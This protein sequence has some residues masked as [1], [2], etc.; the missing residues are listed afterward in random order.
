MTDDLVASGIEKTALNKGDKIPDFNLNDAFGNQVSSTELL[1]QG[2]LV[3]SFY[4][5]GWC[6]FCSLELKALHEIHPQIKELG[7]NLIAISPQLN[8]FSLE[9]VEKNGFKFSVLSDIDNKV[10]ES[11]GLV[12]GLSKHIANLY[13]FAFDLDLKAVNGSDNMALHIP[14]TYICAPD[15]T[16]DYAF[17]DADHSNRLEPQQIIDFLKSK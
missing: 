4:R 14:A 16:I 13:R 9:N 12:F 8:K 6:P 15:G 1:K 3:I 5:G 10:A 11:F 17:V 7:A 2:P